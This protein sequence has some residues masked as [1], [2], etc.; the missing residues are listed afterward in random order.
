VQKQ[1]LILTERTVLPKQGKRKNTDIDGVTCSHP[2]NGKQ[3]LH[4]AHCFF[5]VTRSHPISR[6]Q[7]FFETEIN[8]ALIGAETILNTD[9][10]NHITQAREE[11]EY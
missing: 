6:K 9:R 3:H 4:T 5:S 1:Y 7:N 10:A 8:P 11:K 2:V